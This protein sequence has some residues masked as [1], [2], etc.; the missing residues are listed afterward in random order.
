M[1]NIE[2]GMKDIVQNIYI[3][4]KIKAPKIVLF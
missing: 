1:V 2:P 3:N 4:M